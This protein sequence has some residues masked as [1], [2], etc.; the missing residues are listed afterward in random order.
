MP[1]NRRPGSERGDGNRVRAREQEGVMII[2]VFGEQ[3]ICAHWVPDHRRVH[4][5]G[6]LMCARKE[7]GFWRI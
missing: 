4:R 3:A 1:E 6:M 7:A 2:L 5:L